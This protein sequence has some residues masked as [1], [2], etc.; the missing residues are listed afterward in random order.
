[1]SHCISRYLEYIYWKRN[2][3][4]EKKSHVVQLRQFKVPI[5]RTNLSSLTSIS[6]TYVSFCQY[7]Q[8]ISQ[9]SICT[10][11]R[12]KVD[13]ANSRQIQFLIESANRKILLLLS[14][15]ERPQFAPVLWFS[16]SPVR[17]LFALYPENVFNSS[18]SRHLLLASLLSTKYPST[19]LQSENTRRVSMSWWLGEHEGARSDTIS[20]KELNERKFSLSFPPWFVSMRE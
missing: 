9:M 16:P 14:A 6:R 19:L 12:E 20:G 18:L 8:K 2:K 17:F 15:I 3:C 11:R 10:K 5:L 7:N 4:N 13:A 1:M